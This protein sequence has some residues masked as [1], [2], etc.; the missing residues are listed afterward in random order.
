MKSLKQTTRGED[1]R[2][3]NKTQTFIERQKDSKEHL[4]K[5]IP[6]VLQ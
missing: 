5:M 1:A 2:S 6:F 4:V 3:A